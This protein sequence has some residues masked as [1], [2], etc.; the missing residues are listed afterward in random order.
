MTFKLMKQPKPTQIHSLVG[1]ITISDQGYAL[2][3]LSGNFENNASQNLQDV[4]K[5]V[6]SSNIQYIAIDLS[7]T[8]SLNSLMIGTILSFSCQLKKHDGFICFI[9]PPAQ[10]MTTLKLTRALEII[11]AY[12]SLDQLTQLIK[13][14]H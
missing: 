8:K 12:S 3:T 9:N 10:F 6:F 2:I 4:L 7:H 11:P 5:S 1:T 14:N 13:N